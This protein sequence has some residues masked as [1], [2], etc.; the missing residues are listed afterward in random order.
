[1]L[2]QRN[3]KMARLSPD[4]SF[5]LRVAGDKTIQIVAELRSQNEVLMETTTPEMPD[6]PNGLYCS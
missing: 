4:H 2:A 1:M 3:H 6:P 5:V